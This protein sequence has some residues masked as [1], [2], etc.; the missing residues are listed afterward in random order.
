[1]YFLHSPEI[2]KAYPQLAA[3]M[4]FVEGVSAQPDVADRVMR[5]NA[6]AEARLASGSEGDFPEIQ[7]WR[8]V[9]SS[10]GLKPTQYRCSS[11]SL[12]R[13]FRKEKLLAPIHPLLDLCN[14]ISM[15]FAIP[16]AVFDAAKISVHMEVRYAS[17]SEVYQPFSGD[18]EHPEPREVI[19]ADDADRA[20]ARRWTHRQSGYSAIR[21]ETTA[22]LIV[23]EAMHASAAVDV[24]KLMAA[25]AEEL[26]GAW[27]AFPVTGIVNLYSPKF[28]FSE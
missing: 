4:L 9:F 23:A 12:L 25:I 1:M 15:A 17:G 8:R 24:D 10:M 13:R 7:A 18:E 2:W 11:E 16:V 27:P 6:V 5:W 19:F 14:S 26:R 20:H 28:S 3:G 22:V 21:E